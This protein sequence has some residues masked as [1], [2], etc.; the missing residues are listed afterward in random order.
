[1]AATACFHHGSLFC[2]GCTMSAIYCQTHK[3]GGCR[4]HWILIDGVRCTTRFPRRCAGAGAVPAWCLGV[5]AAGAGC[6]RGASVP[7]SQTSGAAWQDASLGCSWRRSVGC[8]WRRLSGKH[9]ATLCTGV[10]PRQSEHSS[11]RLAARRGQCQSAAH[12]KIGIHHEMHA[13]V[14]RRHAQTCTG[15]RARASGGAGDGAACSASSARCGAGAAALLVPGP[16]P[17]GTAGALRGRRHSGATFDT[18]SLCAT[19][20]R[21]ATCLLPPAGTIFG[22]FSERMRV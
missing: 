19:R 4:V 22:L 2:Y 14:S 20:R 8:A 3:L 10:K 13:R 15:R 11:S 17:A 1:M 18:A 21:F 7:S 9:A 5:R 16:A 6:A 12:H